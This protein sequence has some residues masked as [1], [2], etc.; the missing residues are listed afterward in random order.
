[1]ASTPEELGASGDLVGRLPTLGYK[2]RCGPNDL[3]HDG[4]RPAAP[5]RRKR[6]RRVNDNIAFHPIGQVLM[7]QKRSAAVVATKA[8]CRSNESSPGIKLC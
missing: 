6:T 8:D 5:L 1:M 7:A 3:I 4:A 2:S